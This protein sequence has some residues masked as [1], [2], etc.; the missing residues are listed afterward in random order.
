MPDALLDHVMHFLRRTVAP[1]D[2]EG[3]GELLRRFVAAGEEAA[4][5]GLV[6]R[7]AAMVFGVCR[8]LLNDVHDAEDAF[9]ATFL[10]LARRA[11]SV[12][13]G[14]SVASFLYGVAYR[15]ARKARIA[16]ARRH[17]AEVAPAEPVSPADPVAEAAWRELRRVIDEEL[18]R[19]PEKYRAPLVLC[20]LE[21]KTNEEA[22]RLLGWTKGTVSGRLARA[23]DLLRPRLAR[24]GLAL[25]AGGLAAL[26]AHSAAAPAV[27]VE[28]TVKAVLASGASA[29]AAALAQG[30]L[31]AMFAK[32]LTT[33]AAVVLALGLA[34][35]GVGLLRQPG[36]AAAGGGDEKAAPK[37]K[38]GVIFTL[39]EVPKKEPDDLDKMQGTWQA[40]AL[41]HDGEK[42]PAEAIKTFRVA[43]HDNTITFDPDGARREASFMLG[44]NTKPKAIWLK[45]NAKASMVRGIYALEDG[46][47]KICVDNDEGKATPSEFATKAGSGLTLITLERAG[48][49]KAGKEQPKPAEKRYSF[50]INN[51]PWKEVFEWFG[52]QT[53]LVYNG[54]LV[55]TGTFTFV[56]PRGKQ[57]TIPEIVDIINEALMAQK[58][59]LIVHTNTFTVVPVDEPISGG[60]R[61]LSVEDLPS[62]DKNET[63]RLFVKLKEGRAAEVA[64]TLRKQMSPLGEAIPI[65]EINGLVLIDTVGTL[66]EVLKTLK[67]DET[68]EK[69]QSP[70]TEPRVSLRPMESASPVRAVTFTPHT[71]VVASCAEDGRVILWHADSGKARAKLAFGDSWRSL[72]VSPDGKLLAIGGSSTRNQ[73]E[74][75]VIRVL[76]GETGTEVGPTLITQDKVVNGVAFSPDGNL[77]A[78]SGGDGVIRVWD[79][80]TS[81]ER[82]S[83]VARRGTVTAVAISPG[84]QLLASAGADGSINLADFATGKLLRTMESDKGKVES[85]AFS[86]DGNSLLTAGRDQPVRLWDATTGKQLR[87]LGGVQVRIDAAA[88]SP[89]GKRIAWG[90]EHGAVRLYDM[91]TSKVVESF[92]GGTKAVHAVA[93]SP[94]GKTLATGGADGSVNLWDVGK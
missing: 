94:D 79:L 32:K 43:I 20:Y 46:R 80:R 88:F 18:D 53:G 89:D 86:P 10:V 57:Y 63:G 52:E 70:R 71:R 23:R 50:S 27:L 6:R 35:G 42:L 59:I 26:L 33:L 30:V 55:P 29:P 72:A 56:S 4:F 61:T 21:G 2:G 36:P 87:G 24:R 66:R 15:V 5:A 7:H 84:G 8:R 91:A 92:Q 17:Q 37:G 93:F 19:L 78:S 31:R 77:L 39:P 16:A 11:S 81:K 40:V 65:E 67:I 83:M 1:A 51:R 25:P 68:K 58:Y 48:G 3:D 14:D 62:M 44:T 74:F 9:Q 12:R 90:D 82:L 45:A 60:K 76:N 75:G 41:E 13:Q 49:E 47:L 73:V 34:G 22:A 38:A 54:P 28:M 69:P 85:L 64:R